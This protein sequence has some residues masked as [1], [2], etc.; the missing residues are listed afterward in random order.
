MTQVL[1]KNNE[2]EASTLRRAMGRF[3]TGI[4][5]ISAQHAGEIHAMTANAICTISFEPL[6]LMVCVNKKAKMNGFIQA[7]N[8]FAVNILAEKQ[9]IVSRHFAGANQGEVPKNLKFEIVEETP[10]L[11]GTLAAIACKIDKVLDAG[12]HVMILGQ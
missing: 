12:D 9:E 6:T 5:V 1:I 7:A 4:T 8:C 10:L 2:L 3:A 11:E